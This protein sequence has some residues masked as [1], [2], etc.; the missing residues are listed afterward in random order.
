M[1]VASGVAPIGVLRSIL[2]AQRHGTKRASFSLH[3]QVM[4]GTGVPG[5]LSPRA[6]RH[7]S[8]AALALSPPAL[9]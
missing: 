1:V 5:S 4:N 7:K 3:R 8:R 6:A 9:A 2:T